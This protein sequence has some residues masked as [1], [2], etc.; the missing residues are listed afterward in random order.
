[1]F[2]GVM[3]AAQLFL[4][5]IKK[6]RLLAALLTP[7]LSDLGAACRECHQRIASWVHFE[8]SRELP[9]TARIALVVDQAL[10]LPQN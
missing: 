1:M 7:V 3:H 2:T 6:L 8:R 5:R 9:W 4:L 10:M